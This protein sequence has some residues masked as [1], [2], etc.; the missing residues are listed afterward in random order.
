MIDLLQ[1]LNLFLGSLP[2]ALILAGIE[3]ELAMNK[4]KIIITGF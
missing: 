2:Q 1:P 3:I 4:A